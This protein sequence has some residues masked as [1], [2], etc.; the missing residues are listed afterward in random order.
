MKARLSAR[1]RREVL[2][3]DE[4]WRTRADHKT[5]FVDELEAMLTKLGRDSNLGTRYDA[6]TRERILRTRLRRSQYYVYYTM[7]DDEVVV[8]S[9]WSALRGQQPRL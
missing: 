2:R 9:V 7:N 6:L 5:L 4:N 1:A 8:L 3:I